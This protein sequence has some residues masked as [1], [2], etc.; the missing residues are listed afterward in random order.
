MTVAPTRLPDLFLEGIEETLADVLP[1]IRSHMDEELPNECVGLV[2]YDRQIQRLINQARSPSR[3][4]V[5]R[6]Q[7]AERLAEMDASNLL[8]CVY[9]SHPGGSIQMSWDDKR[10]MKDQW[11]KDI[12]VPWLIVTEEEA[13]L[14]YLDDDFYRWRHIV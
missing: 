14:H 5:S 11:D 13:T 8:V 2:W 12:R 9:H 3:F 7:L 4:T 1:E 6:A 10:S